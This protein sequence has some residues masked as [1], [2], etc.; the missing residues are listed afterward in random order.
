MSILDPAVRRIAKRARKTGSVK[1]SK[2]AEYLVLIYEDESAM[3]G[4][5]EEVFKE[6]MNGH[7][8]FGAR[9]G[10]SIRGGNALQPSSTA[11]SLRGD[12][13]GGF[14]IT[15]GAFSETKEALGGYYLLEA[16]DLDEAIA[17]AKALPVE[18]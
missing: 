8:A 2:M 12:G 6:M 18:R 5:G 9:H 13:S 1:G 4:A 16:V 10:A 17:L 3:E 15:D 7:E 14:S 11:T